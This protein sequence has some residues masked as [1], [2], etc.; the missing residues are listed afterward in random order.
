MPAEELLRKAGTSLPIKATHDASQRKFQQ[1]AAR[2][3]WCLDGM[4]VLQAGGLSGSVAHW[5]FAAGRTN[6]RESKQEER[7][8][9]EMLE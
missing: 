7:R 2:T 4:S 1:F 9:C 6:L 8:T 5:L 3:D